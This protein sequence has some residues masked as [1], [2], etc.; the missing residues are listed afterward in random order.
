MKC[1]IRCLPGMGKSLLRLGHW[2]AELIKHYYANLSAVKLPSSA[3]HHRGEAPSRFVPGG[4]G[5]RS[6]VNR[7]INLDFSF[8]PPP[9]PLLALFIRLEHYATQARRPAI[10]FL[11]TIGSFKI[12]SLAVP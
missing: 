11:A 7:L 4:I 3:P 12:N 9:P 1:E 5:A 8:P 6:A 10:N 2:T